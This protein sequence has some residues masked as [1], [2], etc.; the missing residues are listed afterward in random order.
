M[1][2]GVMDRSDPAEC[3]RSGETG[4][5]PLAGDLRTA[6]P[7]YGS[8]PSP[9]V[10]LTRPHR[11]EADAVARTGGPPA[12]VASLVR[13][14]RAL[15]IEEGSTLLVHSSLS[16]LGWV[17]GGAEAAILALEGALGEAGTL[18]MPAY[19]MSFPEPALW[20]DPPVPEAWWEVV[21]EEWP[22]FDPD[23]SP[24]LRLGT[25]AETFRHQRGTRRSLHPNNSFCARGPNAHKLLDD[26]ALDLSMGEGS[27]LARLYDLDGG[28]LLLG[29]DHSSNSSY[30]LAEYRANWPG[31]RAT[32]SFRGRMI[33]E[34]ATVDCVLQDLDLDS[35]DFAALGEDFEK[36]LGLVR[37]H[38]V[39]L[40][41][42]HLMRQRAAVD[43][44]VR[45]IE[46]HRPGIVRDDR[47]SRVT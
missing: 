19:S 33:R 15:G 5:G 10:P 7:S 23:F 30:H 16:S 9:G 43:F 13:D 11:G 21:R 6:P 39:A 31:Q 46:T 24:A 41:T 45:W 44:A 42:A 34:G 8:G 1:R 35:D 40:A 25:I 29:V 17:V 12:T 47:S 36:E 3:A 18:M 27:P 2:V 20:E 37:T 4:G 26:H 22:P 38:R 28:I 32:R 14:L